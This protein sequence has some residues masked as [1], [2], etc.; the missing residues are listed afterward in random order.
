MIRLLSPSV[1]LVFLAQPLAAFEV[2]ADAAA[3]DS[4]FVMWMDAPAPRMEKARVAVQPD[5]TDF[6]LAREARHLDF[7]HALPL[8]NGRLGA[9]DFGG[10][11]LLRVALNEQGVWSGGEYAW[12]QSDA[13]EHLPEIRRLIFEDRV[14][15]AFKLMEEH[16]TWAKGTKRFEPT[17]FGAYQT[18]GDLIVSFPES[19]AAAENFRRE[20]DVMTGL[21][22]TRF[23]RGGVTHT[24]RLVVSKPA[25]IIAMVLENDRPGS[26]DF[27]ATLARPA[28]ASIRNTDDGIRLD[29]Q[30]TFDMP[31]GVGTRFAALLDVIVD[32]GTVVRGDD[33]IRV[34]GADRAVI[35]VSAGSSLGDPDGW[36][37]TL[38]ERLADARK[39]SAEKLIAA[40]TADHHALM[41]RC[42]LNLPANN[43]SL[44][45]LPVRVKRAQSEPDPALD[46]LYFQFGRHLLVSSS[47]A[48]SRLPA[49]L[50]GL[51]AEEIRTPWN[52]DFHSNINLQMNYWPAEP[53]N[54]SECHL[55]LMRLIQ[56]TARQGEATARA[57]YDAPGWVA[58]H[59]QNPWGYS[60]PS[61]VKAGSG[62]TCGAWLCW[63]IWKHYE[64]TRDLEFLREHLPILTGATEFFLATLIEDPKTGHWVT[65]PSMSP[66]NSYMLPH[67]ESGADQRATLTYGATYDMQILRALFATTAESIRLT[68]GDESLARRLDETRAKLAPTRLGEDGRILEWIREFREAE[69]KHRHV[70][71]LWGL[72]PGNEIHPGTP[73]L[74]DGARATLEA[75]GDASTGW[76]MAWK[77][78]FWA[79]LGNPERSHKLYRMLIGRG[80][81]NLFCLHPPFQIDGNFGGTAAV[82]EMLLQCQSTDDQGRRVIHMLPA[83][84]PD[85]KEGRVAGLRTRGGH[86]IAISWN[87]TRIMVEITGGVAEE[88]VIRLG[89]E[90][91]EARIA[92]DQQQVFVF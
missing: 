54:L 61:N 44:L 52:A 76:S 70:S 82:A 45:P 9:M 92:P 86:E 4:P 21:A 24:R 1:G 84:P 20:L 69:P 38:V 2:R 67:P 16:F 26:L 73:E 56:T 18:L 78:N 62:A 59:T 57:Y 64:Y 13:H 87:P 27:F 6:P 10:V 19:D 75:R 46:A 83:L 40:A 15:E 25:E 50:Q 35:F 29:G 89:N 28:Q 33:G 17:Q 31:G 14:E 74:F 90:S 39:Q 60:A 63:H 30:L 88:V 80:A 43:A 37:Q 5:G 55:P 42:T 53:T 65:S 32:G 47:R 79:R 72:H 7:H 8:G 12:N 71:H 23:E 91:R 81:P 41:A 34:T 58:H 48:D 36:E 77:A 22:T 51:W 11:E 85:W 3:P 68:G 49:N 66:E